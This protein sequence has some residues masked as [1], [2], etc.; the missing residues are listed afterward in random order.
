GLFSLPLAPAE[1]GRRPLRAQCSASEM[2]AQEPFF[3]GPENALVRALAIAVAAD[4]PI[5]N[6]IVLYGATGVGKSSVAL[7]LAV[8]RR[9]VLQ[10]GGAILTTGADFA[11]GLA[12]AVENDS[13]NDLRAKYHRCDLLLIDDLHQLA[14]KLPAQQFLLVA[15]DALV[16]RGSLVIATLRAALGGTRRVAGL[17]A[18]L[19]SRLNGG[20]FVPIAPPGPL[21]GG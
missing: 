16:R 21:A 8:T 5:Y 3:A 18:P 6:P 19:V 10:L 2:P 1:P 12:E 17:T 20:L 13:V 7:A 15:I 11:R 9:H 14:S 4:P